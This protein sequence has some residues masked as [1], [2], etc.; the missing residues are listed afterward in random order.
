M[1][2]Y[3]QMYTN[4]PFY[5]YGSHIE[6][7]RFKEHNFIGCPR[8]ISKFRLYFQVLFGAFFQ[9]NSRNKIVMGKKI[10]V[11]CLDVIMIAFFPRNIQ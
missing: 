2:L 10:L 11:P 1:L 9:K 8:N 7:I 5:R 4:R 6:F 3:G